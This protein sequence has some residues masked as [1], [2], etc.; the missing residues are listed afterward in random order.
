MRIT[1]TNRYALAWQFMAE[2]SL[3]KSYVIRAIN[4]TKGA[5]NGEYEFFVNRDFF[6]K[7]YSF[8]GLSILLAYCYFKFCHAS[9]S[10][11]PYFL[12]GSPKRFLGGCL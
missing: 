7:K 3:S 2:H 1:S 9:G 10:L 6:G 11:E 12:E 8:F 4:F 5:P